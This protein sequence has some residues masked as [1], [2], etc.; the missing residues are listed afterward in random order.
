[1]T[2]EGGGGAGEKMSTRKEKMGGS[3][4]AAHISTW[5]AIGWCTPSCPMEVNL[6]SLY[7]L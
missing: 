5:T 7:Y 3:K 2:A 4:E 6:N 1:M